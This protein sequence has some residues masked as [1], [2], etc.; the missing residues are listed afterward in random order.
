MLVTADSGATSFLVWDGRRAKIDLT[1]QTIR[2]ALNLTTQDAPRPISPSLLNV[3]R[4]TPDITVPTVDIPTTQPPYA[5]ALGVQV[6][7]VFGLT[8]SD[9][10]Q[11]IYVALPDGYQQVTPLVGDLIRIYYNE[12]KQLPLVAP[13]LLRQAPVTQQP[14]N[15]GIYPATRPDIVGYQQAPTM[16]VARSGIN[17][18]TASVYALLGIPLAKE[19]KPVAVTEPGP[20][21]VDSVY[22]RPGAGAVF[23]SATTGEVNGSHALFVITDQGIA[24]PVV[25]GAALVSLGYTANDVKDTAPEL[26]ALLPRGP[27]LD[28]DVAV[29]FYPQSGISAQSLPTPTSSGASPSP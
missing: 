12:A 15:L 7:E 19:A 16:C 3:I 10:T 1:N 29:H 28:P 17:P 13:E 27:T 20:L 26:L 8:R 11:A 14:I 23:S 21:T 24:Y 5:T 9:R 25:S 18:S 2:L 22:L 6:G 4:E